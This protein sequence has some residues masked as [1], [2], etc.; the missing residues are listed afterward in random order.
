[1]ETEQ[2]AG[3]IGFPDSKIL[4]VTSSFKKCKKGERKGG[5]SVPGERATPAKP[6]GQCCLDEASGQGPLGERTTLYH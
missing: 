6:A 4:A 1:M 5:G 3:M 2:T